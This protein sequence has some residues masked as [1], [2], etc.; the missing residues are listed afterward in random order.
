MKIEIH[1]DW[2]GQGIE[3]RLMEEVRE[4]VPELATEKQTS[5]SRDCTKN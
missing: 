3:E 2:R 1:P 4:D 5:T